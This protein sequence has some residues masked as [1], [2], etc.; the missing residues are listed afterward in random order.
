M[1]E[2]ELI[3]NSMQKDLD[4][5]KD[6]YAAMIYAASKATTE[7]N[8]LL[9][10]FSAKTFNQMFMRLK[11]MEQ[12]AEER[13]IQVEQIKKV[14]VAM[15]KQKEKLNQKRIEKN[16]LLKVQQKENRNLLSL[17]SEK[18]SLVKELS[19]REKQLVKELN[20]RKKALTKLDRE[21][22]EAIAREIKKT[23]SGNSDKVTLNNETA[24][25]SSSFEGS[26]S[27]L[28]WPV[29]SGFVSQKYGRQEHAVLK[30]IMIENKGIDIQT[31]KGEVVKSVFDGKVDIVG[32]IPGVGTYIMINHGEYFTIYA[33]L[34][35]V[36]VK[37]GEMV[38]ARQVLGD[39][40]IDRDGISELHFEIWKNHNNL[41]PEAWLSKH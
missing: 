8:K 6:E 15:L 27:R 37:K 34:A 33:R 24:V 36:N 23:S 3:A 26:R 11:F 4:D 30:G 28:A 9:F 12:Y 7:K 32:F 14:R 39:V 19:S 18:D 21:I 31:S 16:A 17:K 1:K 38:K 25:L 40:L 29:E 5:L 41:D 13:K 10:I 20:E 35:K 22:A 2:I